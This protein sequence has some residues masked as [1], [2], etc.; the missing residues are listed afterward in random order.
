MPTPTLNPGPSP[1]SSLER[2]FSSSSLRVSPSKVASPGRMPQKSFG[3]LPARVAA[4]PV[5]PTRP[6]P[7]ETHTDDLYSVAHDSDDSDIEHEAR[8]EIPTVIPRKDDGAD[9]DRENANHDQEKAKLQAE[10]EALQQELRDLR[11]AS[12]KR[13]NARLKEQLKE[14]SVREAAQEEQL[15]IRDDQ[16]TLCRQEL[17]ELQ[18]HQ[19]KLENAA[20]ARPA[21]D[22]SGSSGLG[23]ERELLKLVVRLVGSSNVRTVLREN[24]NATPTQLHDALVRR[25]TQY[26]HLSPSMRSTSPPKS[27]G[28]T[29]A[30]SLHE[31][32]FGARSPRPPSPYK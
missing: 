22:E 12:S 26:R 5:S 10:I 24:P 20:P 6:P 19:L 27:A 4:A 13:D 25:C 21:V 31:L 17:R 11:D 32:L 23:R 29:Q 2:S 7:I 16:L 15:G 28:T 1:V 18:M 8:Q 30:E 3:R 14:A 9:H